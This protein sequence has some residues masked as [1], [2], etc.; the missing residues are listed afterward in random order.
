[1]PLDTFTIKLNNIYHCHDWGGVL[2]LGFFLEKNSPSLMY[3]YGSDISDT[4]EY[5]CGIIL[6]ILYSVT[7]SGCDAL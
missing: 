2:L 5:M 4:S 7:A 6:L 3:A 1:M